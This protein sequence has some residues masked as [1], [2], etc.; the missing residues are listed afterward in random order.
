M[1]EHFKS[2]SPKTQLEAD[3]EAKALAIERNGEENWDNGN[4]PTNCKEYNAWGTP[5]RETNINS[6][7]D[8]YLQLKNNGPLYAYYASNRKAHLVVVTG[9]NLFQG[10]VYT[11]NPHGYKGIQTYNQFLTGFYGGSTDGSYPLEFY[12][13]TN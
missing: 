10:V 1:V 3:A 13:L 6:I 2:G 4:W 9:V 8:L 11:N 7:F 12:I 5:I